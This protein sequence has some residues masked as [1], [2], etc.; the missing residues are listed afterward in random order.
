MNTSVELLS[1]DT[2]FL[3]Y[4]VGRLLPTD[5][6]AASVQELIA[7]ARLQKIR[8]LYWSVDP[9]DA[10]AVITAELVGAFLADRKV[11]YA[12]PV[13]TLPSAPSDCITTTTH[14][15]PQLVSLALQSGHQSRFQNDPGFDSDVFERLYTHWIHNSVSGEIAREVLIYRAPGSVQEQ[16]L[17]TLGVK[18]GRT[19][20]GLLAVDVRARSQAI[21]YQLVQASHQRA[22]AWG[23][24]ILQVVTQRTNAGACR[25]YERCGFMPEIVEHIY[26]IWLF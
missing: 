15:T 11:T 12:M 8:L 22:Y 14:L 2:K 24:D 20:I 9:A 6:A 23:T 17:M 21:G 18:K 10:Q 26:H 7:A 25:F 13:R 1:W 3:G 4:R 16:G 5:S 19:D